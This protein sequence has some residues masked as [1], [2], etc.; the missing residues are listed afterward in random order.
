MMKHYDVIIV[1]AGVVGSAI[2]R[3]LSRYEINMAV[4]ARLNVL[5]NALMSKLCQELKVKIENI[6][7]L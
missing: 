4:R 7:K 5:G 2:A 1:G 6:G 3:E